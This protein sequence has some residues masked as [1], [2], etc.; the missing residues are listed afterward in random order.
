MGLTKGGHTLYLSCE[1]SIPPWAHSGMLRDPCPLPSH[2]V[3]CGISHDPRPRPRP[4]ARPQILSLH[5][6]QGVFLACEETLGKLLP[7]SQ[8]EREA[9]CEDKVSA[10]LEL[11]SQPEQA[12]AQAS[13]GESGR[14]LRWGPFCPLTEASLR[15]NRGQRLGLQN[16]L[17]L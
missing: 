9:C 4:L 14:L 6:L 10:N 8:Q 3:S 1:P 15:V 17:P 5:T 12:A 2:K 16:L 7:Q 13:G 11:N